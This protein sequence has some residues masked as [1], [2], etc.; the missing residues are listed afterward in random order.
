MFIP[1]ARFSSG[2]H[3]TSNN[4]LITTY[5]DE[6]APHC[7]SNIYAALQ[8]IRLV[9]NVLAGPVLESMG[10]WIR[11]SR[12]GENALVVLFVWFTLLWAGGGG[13]VAVV[14]V[15]SRSGLGLGLSDGD[16][17]SGGGF[18]KCLNGCYTLFFF[19][20]SP[21]IIYKMPSPRSR[22]VCVLSALCV[23][24]C[25]SRMVNCCGACYGLHG[26]AFG[27]FF[28]IAGFLVLGC[29]QDGKKGEG[30]RNN[31]SGL[32]WSVGF[33]WLWGCEMRGGLL[34]VRYACWWTMSGV[35]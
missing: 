18:L 22:C 14:V 25:L 28:L 17:S 11:V 15:V 33:T 2:N 13:V 23:C 27:S 1:L 3:A 34:G 26:V 31:V 16:G 21:C 12:V 4:K 30:R 24:V 19:F 35:F 32:I 10:T 5:G 29:F 8:K 9:F 7:V 20:S 6:V